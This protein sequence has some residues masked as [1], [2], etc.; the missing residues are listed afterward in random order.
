MTLVRRTVAGYGPV[1]GT[2]PQLGI[3]GP[4]PVL[5]EQLCGVRYH[6]A[7][8]SVKVDMNTTCQCGI[9]A[10]G[11]C[12]DCSRYICGLHGK[13]HGDR[14]TCIDDIEHR[15][16]EAIAAKKREDDK[17][18]VRSEKSRA[19]SIVSRVALGDDAIERWIRAASSL[20]MGAKG[21][22]SDI[23][24]RYAVTARVRKLIKTARGSSAVRAPKGSPVEQWSVD[25]D[26]IVVW[27][28]SKCDP[29]MVVNTGLL[30]TIEGWHIGSGGS[31][32]TPD[33]PDWEYNV[34]LL[35]DGR[36]VHVK[37]SSTRLTSYQRSISE[38]FGSRASD[39]VYLARYLDY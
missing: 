29:D 26:D 11:Q 19:E 4:I 17:E 30:R 1:P 10:I 23:M 33:D 12:S 37:K 39:M 2:P 20:L 28:R 8:D 18:L 5:V 35:I 36:V 32:D 3:M 25:A 27:L 24:A 15:H 22:Q 34:I 9:F 31:S 14:L 13:L 7:D 38:R 21:A 16:T 6:E